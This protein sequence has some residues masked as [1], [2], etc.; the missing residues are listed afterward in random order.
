M[1]IKMKITHYSI[2]LSKIFKLGTIHLYLLYYWLCYPSQ[3]K[4]DTKRP[5]Y[6]ALIRLLQGKDL[7]VRV[8]YIATCYYC[9]TSVSLLIQYVPHHQCLDSFE[10]TMKFIFLAGSLSIAV[11]TY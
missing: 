2:T 6:C 3:I 4:D 1:F 10:L 7:S 9:F 8:C 11:L 5:V